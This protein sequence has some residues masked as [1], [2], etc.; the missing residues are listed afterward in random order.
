MAIKD[1]DDRARWL[2]DGAANLRQRS[3]F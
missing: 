1:G 2:A 3:E